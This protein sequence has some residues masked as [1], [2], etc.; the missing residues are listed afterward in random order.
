MKV[1]EHDG[2]I[3]FKYLTYI[4]GKGDTE[5]TDS[6]PKNKINFVEKKV[7]PRGGIHGFSIRSVEPYDYGS[8]ISPFKELIHFSGRGDRCDMIDE[9]VKITGVP[10]NEILE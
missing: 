1:F 6:I 3:Y 7:G 2:D 9:F 10:V 4:E 5:V 8:G